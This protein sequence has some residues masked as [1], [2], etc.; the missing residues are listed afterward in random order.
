MKRLIAPVLGIL[1]LVL[2][3]TLAAAAEPP[4]AV[5]TLRPI[6]A[7]FHSIQQAEAAG[8]VR[9]SPCTSS[10]AGGMGIHYENAGLMADPAVD[11]ASPE[12]LVYFPDENGRLKLVAIEYW[13]TDADGSLTTTGD[14]PVLFGKGFN[15]P[16]PGHHPAMP[17]HYDLHVWV[18]EH[19]PAGL[20]APFNP[21]LT[22]PA[23]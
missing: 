11:I 19:N 10:P 9:M 4:D 7:R 18:W 6:T 21:T 8:Y 1:G 14:R 2:S 13:K 22:C 5:S 12:I 3:V 15:G 17:A 20:F 16:M 23:G